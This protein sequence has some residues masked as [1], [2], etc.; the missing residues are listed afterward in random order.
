MRML[1]TLGRPALLLFLFLPLSL[2]GQQ[3]TTEKTGLQIEALVSLGAQGTVGMADRHSME[4]GYQGQALASFALPS[5]LE[6]A[7][8][9]GFT[10]ERWNVTT[11]PFGSLEF[12]HFFYL[13]KLTLPLRVGWRFGERAAFRVYAGL[14]PWLSL[15]GSLDYRTPGLQLSDSV[16]DLGGLDNIMGVK[17][18]FGAEI[19]F[20]PFGLAGNLGVAMDFSF[21]LTPSFGEIEPLGNG[22]RVFSMQFSVVYR[23]PVQRFGT[24][25]IPD[26]PFEEPQPR[27]VQAPPEEPKVTD[28]VE[29]TVEPTIQTVRAS[30]SPSVAVPTS[31]YV[32]TSRTP[33]VLVNADWEHVK[34]ASIRVSY[35]GAVLTE[36]PVNIPADSGSIRVPLALADGQT[37]AAHEAMDVELRVAYQENVEGRASAAATWR[38]GP[39]LQAVN[40]QFGLTERILLE[41]T[42]SDDVR[43]WNQIPGTI[44][45]RLRDWACALQQWSDDQPDQQW[46]VLLQAETET[47]VSADIV[48]QLASFGRQVKSVLRTELDTSRFTRIDTGHVPTQNPIMGVNLGNQGQDHRQA[49]QLMLLPSDDQRTAS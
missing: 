5:G 41:W 45:D 4:V 37:P 6:W 46:M 43:S 26:D 16:Y 29:P 42:G 36:Q 3:I 44:Q 19:G 22:V 30:V 2:P 15:A 35:G 12:R 38:M 28:P 24:V 32:K 39:T 13:S 31:C 20:E 23:L 9:L 17:G 18:E 40:S 25:E 21:D 33:E 49:M 48:E 47:D 1:P 34:E 8:G 27:L 10:Q 14:T 11:F 7:G